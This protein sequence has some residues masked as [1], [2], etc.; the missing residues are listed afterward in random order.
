MG[1]CN[2]YEGDGE[3]I[4]DSDE[5]DRPPWEFQRRETDDEM[6]LDPDMDFTGTIDA[7]EDLFSSYERT[8]FSS[9]DTASLEMML[10]S[11][12]DEEKMLEED[13]L[14]LSER[15]DHELRAPA[16]PAEHNLILPKTREEVAWR[17]DIAFELSD[18]GCEDGDDRASMMLF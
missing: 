17:E 7:D 2:R 9:Q 14:L 5:H 12:G 8:P 15:Y 6:M 13:L 11:D 1:T 4:L 18:Y 16:V 3:L 10:E